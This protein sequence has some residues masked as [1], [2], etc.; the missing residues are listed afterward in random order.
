VAHNLERRKEPTMAKKTTKK[1]LALSRVTVLNLT[2]LE[3]V[4]GG[5]FLKISSDQICV[6]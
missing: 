2:Q 6:R 1:K 3:G 5:T 4:V